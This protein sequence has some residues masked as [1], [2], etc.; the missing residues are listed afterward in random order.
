MSSWEES[1]SW[2]R[3]VVLERESDPDLVC[4]VLERERAS[5]KG[6][7]NGVSNSLSP[8]FYL[9]LEPSGK[10]Y[11]K[12]Q[13]L[14]TEDEKVQRSTPPIIR[15]R[16]P[17]PRN[18]AYGIPASEW[19]WCCSVSLRKTNLSAKLQMTMASHM[20]RYAVSFVLLLRSK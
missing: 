20:K 11:Q 2:T 17:G 15:H 4:K 6:G 16:R 5:E 3:D 12:L 8:I 14:L 1:V 9:F 13:Y 18:P 7:T 19:R 10:L